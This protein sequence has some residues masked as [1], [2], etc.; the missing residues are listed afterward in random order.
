[1]LNISLLVRT[2]DY[3]RDVDVDRHEFLEKTACAGPGAGEL[4]GLDR[5]EGIATPKTSVFGRM[6]GMLS[7]VV[8]PARPFPRGL[9]GHQ[10]RD[11][12]MLVHRLHL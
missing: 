1:M 12:R 10:A 8:R 11:P 6:A 9:S 3:T 5:Q 7:G 2:G 4:R